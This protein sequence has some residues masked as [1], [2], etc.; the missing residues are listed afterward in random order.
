MG[1][2]KRVRQNSN[3]VPLTRAKTRIIGTYFLWLMNFAD[4]LFKEYAF[5]RLRASQYVLPFYV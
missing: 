4:S 3:H 1:D 2:K 5:L